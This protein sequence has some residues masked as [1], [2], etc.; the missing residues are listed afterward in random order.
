MRGGA[1][2]IR[3]TS[4]AGRR[5]VGADAAPGVPPGKAVM[6]AAVGTALGEVPAAAG[7][8]VQGCQVRRTGKAARVAGLAPGKLGAAAAARP[9]ANPAANPLAGADARAAG[10]AEGAVAIAEGEEAEAVGMAGAPKPPTAPDGVI[11]R[12]QSRV[13]PPTA[14][15]GAATGLPAGR[16]VCGA[17]NPV[18]RVRLASVPCDVARRIVISS[19]ILS[20]APAMPGFATWAPIRLTGNVERRAM[21]AGAVGAAAAG[22]GAAADAGVGADVGEPVVCGI[23]ADGEFDAG[24]V[25]AGAFGVRAAAAGDVDAAA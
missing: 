17:P 21:A 20:S 22:A 12:R 11:V 6:G 19:G 25:D 14:A 15:A 4:R 9:V 3:R 16:I 8:S 23:V 7:A 2:V 5:P 10:L 24:E 13:S 1:T 18:A